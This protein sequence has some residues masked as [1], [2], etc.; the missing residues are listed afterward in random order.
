[1][2]VCERERERTVQG[3]EPHVEQC[4]FREA[5]RRGTASPRKLVAENTAGKQVVSTYHLSKS[6]IDSKFELRQ[7]S[8]KNPDGAMSSPK[9]GSQ[10]APSPKGYA[11]VWEDEVESMAPSKKVVCLC[12]H[13]INVYFAYISVPHA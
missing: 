4:F 11:Q 10:K 3:C 1:M 5:I 8:E 6:K 12:R 13:R 9:S 7:P 2:C